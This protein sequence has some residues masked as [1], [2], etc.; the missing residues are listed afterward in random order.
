MNDVR[1]GDRVRIG[2]G[3]PMIHPMHG[4]KTA[5][6]VAHTPQKLY[7]RVTFNSRYFPFVL[8]GWVTK[9]LMTPVDEL[10]PTP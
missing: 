7:V 1:V 3:D 6:V 2:V 4:G 8:F 9:A 5:V 10:E